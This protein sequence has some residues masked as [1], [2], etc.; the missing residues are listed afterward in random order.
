M[1]LRMDLNAFLPV[2]FGRYASAP[3]MKPCT[4]ARKKENLMKFAASLCTDNGQRPLP[5]A[6]Y[7]RFAAAAACGIRRA[8]AA[9]TSEPK[10][11][12]VSC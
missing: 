11:G 9:K 12:M 10:S 4:K 5:G 6:P 8:F 2:C 1:V 7:W 3:G